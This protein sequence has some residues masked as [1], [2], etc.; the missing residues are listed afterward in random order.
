MEPMGKAKDFWELREFRA[1]G[2]GELGELLIWSTKL[3]FHKALV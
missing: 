2:F 1:Q 3:D